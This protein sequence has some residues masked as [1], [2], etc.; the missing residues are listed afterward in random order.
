MQIPTI[1]VS[2]PQRLADKTLPKEDAARPLQRLDVETSDLTYMQMQRDYI[3]PEALTHYCADSSR[4]VHMH[5]ILNRRLICNN[6]GDPVHS[7]STSV[8]N[9][10]DQTSCKAL[11][12]TFA[13]IL[14]ITLW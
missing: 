6:S 3:P 12:L 7:K 4:T 2:E 9:N 13:D 11:K 5:T 10:H 1:I 8:C 14:L